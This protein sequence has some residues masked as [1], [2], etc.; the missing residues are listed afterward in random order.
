[1]NT[2]KSVEAVRR[3][4]LPEKAET[5]KHNKETYETDIMINVRAYALQ[6]TPPGSREPVP[7]VPAPVPVPVPVPV[8]SWTRE[9]VFQRKS[10]INNLSPQDP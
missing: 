6:Y 8:V 1:M 5:T 2:Q 10:S 7:V 4:Y 3:P 9:G